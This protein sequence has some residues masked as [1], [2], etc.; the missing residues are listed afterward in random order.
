[1]V[2]EE[3]EGSRNRGGEVVVE[4]GVE[5]G[6]RVEGRRKKAWARGRMTRR[7]RRRGAGGGAAALDGGGMVGAV[8]EC[9]EGR[10]AVLEGWWADFA[11]WF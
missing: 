10:L 1:M 9:V 3:Q 11:L 8:V 6:R 4:V 2:D 7:R 5:M